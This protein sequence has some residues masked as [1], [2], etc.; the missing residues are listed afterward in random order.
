MA[1]IYLETSFVSALVTDRK[2]VASLYRREVNCEWWAIQAG[3]YDLFG[4]AEV[5]T[6]LS[7]PDFPL[8][9][10]ALELNDQVPQSGMHSM[11][12]WRRCTT[13]ITS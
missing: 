2:D 12:P 4:A 1:S 10:A 6:E 8:S 7:H 9:G 3:Q 5:I 11:S 13:S